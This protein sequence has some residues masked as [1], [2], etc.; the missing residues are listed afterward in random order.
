MVIFLDVLMLENLIINYFLLS[1]TMQTVRIKSRF[2]YLL[3][4]SFVGCLYVLTILFPE[5]Q[6][7]TKLPFKFISATI[8]IL[9]CLNKRSILTMLRCTIIFFLYSMLL[10]GLII[11]IQYKQND[12]L[13]FS[14]DFT[15]FSFK[16]NML[17]LML[18]YIILQRI[19][20][21]VKDRREIKCF[22]YSI[23]ITTNS[24]CKKVRAFLD[25]GNELREPVTNL[26]VIIVEKTIL[27]S[28]E[29]KECDKFL[30]PYKGINGEMGKIEAFK[31]LL[32]KIYYGNHKFEYRDAII[33]ICESTL[34]EDNDYNAL[35]SRGII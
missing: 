2:F 29:T 26:P 7:L 25:T 9:I 27:G 17:A 11:F 14:V 22:T 4:S 1:I 28:Y 31:P 8:M 32:V 10:C 5:T 6:F 20:V 30:I 23:E 21:Y 18:L 24:M 33:G 16:G 35:L 19:V 15:S 13:M 34:S 3:L 12:E